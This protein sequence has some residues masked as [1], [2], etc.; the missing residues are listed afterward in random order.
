MQQ[1]SN[2]TTAAMNTDVI[3]R[4]ALNTHNKTKWAIKIFGKW[5]SVWRV[6]C[7]EVAKV[8]KPIEEFCKDDLDYALRYFY[9][10]VR[11]QNGER[12]PRL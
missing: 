11:K 12:Y 6:R 1:L 5:L 8:L 10:D 3:D 9:C 4:I 2:T 7:D